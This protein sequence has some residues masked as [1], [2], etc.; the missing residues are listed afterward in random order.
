[1]FGHEELIL[2]YSWARTGLS[3]ALKDSIDPDFYVE[4]KVKRNTPL[5]VSY[6]KDVDWSTRQ[7]FEFFPV[8]GKLQR[9]C[10]IPRHGAVP[11]NT[12]ALGQGKFR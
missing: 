7:R 5:R 4:M 3:A 9:A 1:V 10:I 8:S 6:I 11:C 12:L 2:P